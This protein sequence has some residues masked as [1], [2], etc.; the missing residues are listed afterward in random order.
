MTVWRQGGLILLVAL[1]LAGATAAIHPKRP[2]FL[3]PP[4]DPNEVSLAQTKEWGRSVLWVDARSETEFVAEHIPD[5]ICLNF[6]NWNQQFPKFLDHFNPGQR[7]VVYCSATSCQL[8]REIAEKLRTSGVA[9]AHYLEGG[10]EAW[11][12]GQLEGR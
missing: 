4:Q 9:D 8:S 6:E 7:V 2:S 12:K 10:W 11:K 1:G 3:A 5:A